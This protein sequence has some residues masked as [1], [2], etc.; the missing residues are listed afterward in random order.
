MMHDPLT[1]RTKAG[2]SL[3]STSS[4]FLKVVILRNFRQLSSP[5]NV[6]V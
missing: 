1:L 2:T 6:N 5:V 4:W 3:E